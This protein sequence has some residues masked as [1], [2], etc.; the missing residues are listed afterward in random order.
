MV[1]KKQ[2]AD[3]TVGGIF[4]KLIQFVLPIIATNLLQML[5]N[6]ADMMVVSLSSAENA[7]GAIGTTTSFTHLIVNL[8]I[9]FSVGVNVAVARCIGAKNEERT[10]RV[11]HTALLLALLTGVAGGVV[12]IAV[13]RPILVLMGNT[14]SLL[15]LAVRYTCIYF[16]GVPFLS[17]TNYLIAIFRA[18]GDSKTPLLV[19]S[20][21]GI[22]N[23]VLNLFFVLALG[24]SVEGV[25][26][27]T[28]IANVFSFVVLLIKLRKDKDYT[29][30]SWQKLKM[31][32]SAL[33]EIV[34]IGLP[35]GIQS[36]LFSLSNMLIQSSIVSVNNTLSPVGDYQPITNGNAAAANIEGFV[37]TAMNAVSH[38]MI[39]FTGQNMGANKPERVKPIMYNGFLL[40]TLV[41]VLMS[42]LAI[43]LKNPLLGL[44]GIVEGTEGSLEA[45][46]MQ[47]AT[48][49]IWIIVSP[50]FLA[51]LMEVTIGVLR[52]LGKSLVATVISL[53]G[54]CFLR[55]IWLLTVFPFF[56]NLESI[57]ICYPVTW[58]L[59][60]VASLFVILIFM[61]KKLGE[62]KCL[63]KT[64]I[65]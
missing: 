33:R 3:L 5:Y 47:A 15:T 46:A 53:I 62:K 50:Y 52:G 34:T 37:Y 24:F 30:F 56:K 51:G 7:V 18:K 23:V 16:A 4:F 49:R 64:E 48:V 10:Q 21:A 9:G 31:D 54:V 59:S 44:Y 60:T 1:E 42:G 17:L 41:G 14:G 11:V 58:L 39:T 12:G 61:R 32:R 6:A 40:T 19:L 57:F 26:L 55:V 13:A 35:A 2:R 8:F 27:A 29:T 65:E 25:A 28:A 43:L 38:G 45:L 20:V 22:M 36:A 63:D